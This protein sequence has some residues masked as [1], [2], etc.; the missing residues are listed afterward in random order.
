MPKKKYDGYEL[1][2]F[3]SAYNFRNYQISLIK[4]YLKGNLM[5]VGPGKGELLNYY[6]KYLSSIKLIEPNKKL[7]NLLKK[8][9]INKKLNI[10]NKRINKVKNKF[11]TIIY[12]DVLEHIKKDLNE[13]HQAKKRLVKNG[14]LIFSVPAHQ[15]FYNNFDKSV[16][17]FKRYNKKDFKKMSIKTNLKIEKILY[18]DS[19]GLL[20]IILNKLFDFSNKNL[21]NKVKIWN[22]FIPLSRLVDLITFNKFGKSL[23]CVFKNV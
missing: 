7:F 10:E 23:L 19:I 11:Q 8:K 15:I 20:L 18:Y 3:D 17:H 1:E 22:F 6:K 16:G 4:K 2:Y 12:F 13:V 5:E 14:Y 9:H 21:K